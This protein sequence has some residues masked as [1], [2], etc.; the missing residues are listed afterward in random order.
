V[1]IGG[2]AATHAENSVAVDVE[3]DGAD[4]HVQFATR[5]G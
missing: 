2:D 4:R 5:D 3:F 1:G